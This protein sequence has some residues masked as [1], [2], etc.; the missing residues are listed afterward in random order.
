MESVEPV[1]SNAEWGGLEQTD[2]AL[3]SR[4]P[5]CSYTEGLALRG[6]PNF[7]PYNDPLVKQ[8]SNLV[9]QQILRIEDMPPYVVSLSRQ[10]K[11]PMCGPHYRSSSL[12]CYRSQ[13]NAIGSST[14]HP[15]ASEMLENQQTQRLASSMLATNGGAHSRSASCPV[16]LL[17]NNETRKFLDKYEPNRTCPPPQHFPV[18]SDPASTGILPHVELAAGIRPDQAIPGSFFACPHAGDQVHYPFISEQ[19]R[20]THLPRVSQ[21]DLVLQRLLHNT[22]NYKYP[23]CSNTNANRP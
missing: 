12:D 6:Q 22:P 21:E 16:Y 23:H 10:N 8:E 5:N 19:L 17:N 18:L 1:F 11:S 7:A 14:M 13:D 4:A 2:P 9:S 15:S 3:C 20:E